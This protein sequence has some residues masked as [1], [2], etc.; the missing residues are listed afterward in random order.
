MKREIVK[1][2]TLG[3]LVIPGQ[4]PAPFKAYQNYDFVPG[5]TVLF[6]D[7][8]RSDTDGEFP[9][10]WELSKGQ[11]VVNRIEGTSAFLLTEGNYAVVKPAMTPL[12]EPTVSEPSREQDEPNH[13][14]GPEQ[15]E[16]EPDQ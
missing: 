12:V 6:E 8:F 10:H 5:Q 3:L 16:P 1:A 2:V 14:H 13:H 11:A 4:D 7:D 9:T 15:G